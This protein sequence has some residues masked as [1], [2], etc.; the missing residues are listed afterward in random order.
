[1]TE[2][3]T[4]VRLEQHCRGVRFAITALIALAFSGCTREQDDDRLQQV[5]KTLS[6]LSSTANVVCTAWIAGHASTVYTVATLDQTFMLTEAQRGELV[7]SPEMRGQVRGQ[8][9]TRTAEAL[10][11]SLV[12]LRT[13]V[14]HRDSA[15][16]R[17]QLAGLP[18][19]SS[20]GL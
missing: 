1:M 12:V 9:L 11:R 20:T 6:S 15:A 5:A 4:E 16:L 13:A 14:Q 8:Q 7:R 3:K 18:A 2:A 17:R 10:E 19:S